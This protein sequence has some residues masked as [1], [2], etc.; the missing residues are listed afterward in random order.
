MERINAVVEYIRSQSD[1]DYDRN[2]VM[3]LGI[4]AILER[5]GIDYDGF[6]EHE[7]KLL[8]EEIMVLAIE[9]EID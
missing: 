9:N 3:I 2:M 8:Y 1:F 7:K 5:Y 4:R 6:T